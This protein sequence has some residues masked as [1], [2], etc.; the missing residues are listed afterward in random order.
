MPKPSEF[1]FHVDLLLNTLSTYS[2][3]RVDD[4]LRFSGGTQRPWNF[5]PYTVSPGLQRR[6]CMWAEVVSVL[7]SHF[8]NKEDAL[9]WFNNP[10]NIAGRLQTPKDCIRQGKEYLLIDNFAILLPNARY[11]A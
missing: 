4:L 1:P 3:Y 6:F 2:G 7:S 11:I 8:Q 9:H 5:H 10:Q